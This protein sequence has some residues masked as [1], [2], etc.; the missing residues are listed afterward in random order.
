MLSA[1]IWKDIRVS[2]LPL[3]LTA[4]LVIGSYVVMTI[5]ANMSPSMSAQPWHHVIIGVLVLG[6]LASHATS[7]LSLTV[8]AGNLIAAER[9]D[10]SAEFLA[11]LPASRR[12][13]LGAKALLLAS[14]AVGLLVLHVGGMQIAAI[15]GL[16]PIDQDTSFVTMIVC[17]SA[18]GFCGAGV[19]WLAS[20]KLNS[21]SMAT[22]LAIAAPIL[23][24]TVI[25]I[26]L[27][28]FDQPLLSPDSGRALIVAVWVATGFAG[29]LWGTRH[30]L[31]RV[32]P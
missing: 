4:G 10:R 32:E 23:I 26:S 20:C 15:S 5:M 12:M 13:V 27:L 14:V 8:L 25:Q 19:G 24:P 31:H 22:L 21:N 9:V 7:Q 18:F 6:S 16:P 1:L 17:I 28:A 11:Y 30:F 3:M 2:R 29:F